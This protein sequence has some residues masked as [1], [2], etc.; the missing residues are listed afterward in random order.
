MHVDI[1]WEHFWY[2]DDKFHIYR[3][4]MI[5]LLLYLDV[6]YGLMGHSSSHY[7]SVPL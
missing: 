2:E 6:M 4:L 1:L 3:R 7:C 5:C